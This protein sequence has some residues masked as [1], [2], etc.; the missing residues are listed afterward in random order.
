MT[1][2]NQ[3]TQQLDGVIF[4]KASVDKE[5]TTKDMIFYRNFDFDDF[6]SYF[7]SYFDDF[8]S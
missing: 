3:T 8:L 2:S 5:H 1:S 6:L 4:S 7:L